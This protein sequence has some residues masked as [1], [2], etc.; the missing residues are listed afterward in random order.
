MSL[1][2]KTKNNKNQKLP[3]TTGH[4]WDDNI[5]EY[6]TPAPRW[7]LITWLICIIW[8]IIYSFFYPTLP[9]E[10]RKTS[11]KW[12][13]E[14]QLEES[15]INAKDKQKKYLKIIEN[16]SLEEIKKNLE[17][18]K[19]SLAG[20]EA[21]FKENCAACHGVGAG[22]GNG[23]PNLID[24]A[25]LWGGSLHDIY[26]TIKYG[27]RSAHQKTR[28]S[29]MPRFGLD[30]ILT[31]EEIKNVA[32]HVLSLS[33]KTI[34]TNSKGADI[35]QNQCAICHGKNGKGDKTVGAPNLT[36]FIW[37]YGKKKQDIIKTIFYAR[38]GV[39]PAWVD[40]LSDLQIKQLTIYTHSLGG[41][42]F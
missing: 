36:D 8:A 1:D 18:F 42:E 2:K 5:E 16:S 29:K 19:F 37:L 10:N 27:I 22:G 3:L 17:I 33:D 7:W 11:K 30:E 38:N 24:D 28:S 23:F 15:I 34:K 35:F 20:G 13:S 14:S 39:M 25:W 40:R 32:D 41:G 26:Q 9:T 4:K 6:N 21:N 31:M 12:S